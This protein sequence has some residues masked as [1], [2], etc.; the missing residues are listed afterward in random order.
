M[1][2]TLPKATVERLSRQILLP[3][4][5]IEGQARICHGSVLIVGMGGLGAPVAMYLAGAGVG[6][7]G[8]VD[9]DAVD[10]SNLQRQVIHA[11]HTVGKPK[12]ESAKQF[13]SALNSMVR[14]STFNVKLNCENV[15]EIFAPFDVVVDATDNVATRYLI[16]DCCV[17]A[18]KPL[19]SASALRFEG[20]VTVYGWNTVAQS[21]DR[22]RGPCY[23]CLFPQPP[24]PACVTNCS[25]G[26]ILGAVTGVLGSLQATECIKLL[27]G[28]QP[29]IATLSGR[30]LMFDGRTGDFKSVK[31]RKRSPACAVC[32]D[33]PTISFAQPV[34]YEA[35][36][37][38]RAND[39]PPSTCEIAAAD[40]QRVS[41][42]EYSAIVAAS[43]PHI[44]IDVR[45]SAQFGICHLPHAKSNFISFFV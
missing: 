43:T 25:D 35:F 32:G 30:M 13:V 15:R 18:Q 8:F 40:D 37:G 20:H 41:C 14:V 24:P 23:R 29:G 1:S 11:E 4:I 33:A 21:R 12:V 27:L 39:K 17:L 2:A 6:H 45:D 42:Q 10:E 36:C 7:L 34:D 28:D 31:L 38:S 22:S 26:G 9:Y 19:V 5:G 44:L 3:E 16:N